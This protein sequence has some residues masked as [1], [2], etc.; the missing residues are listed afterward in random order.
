[1]IAAGVLTIIASV[2]WGLPQG[3]GPGHHVTMEKEL[4]NRLVNWR[5]WVATSTI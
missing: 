2:L 3:V 5:F 4:A 1:M